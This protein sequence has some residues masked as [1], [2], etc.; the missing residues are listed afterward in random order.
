[1]TH[2]FLIQVAHTIKAIV[3]PAQVFLVWADPLST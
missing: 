3:Q 1:M 2:L